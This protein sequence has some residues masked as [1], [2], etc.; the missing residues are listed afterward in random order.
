MTADMTTTKIRRRQVDASILDD[1]D[2]AGDDDGKNQQQQQQQQR[3]CPI[4]I[5]LLRY[6]YGTIS[7]AA[8]AAVRSS[9]IDGIVK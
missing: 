3:Q 7:T 4:G 1:D 6:Q 9:S 5:D 2:D 8:A